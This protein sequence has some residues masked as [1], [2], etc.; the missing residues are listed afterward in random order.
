[1]FA[2]RERE[3]ER[4]RESCDQANGGSVKYWTVG[5]FTGFRRRPKTPPLVQSLCIASPSAPP[6]PSY[7]HFLHL[8]VVRSWY[9]VYALVMWCL[10]IVLSIVSLILA[11]FVVSREWVNLGI[12]GAWH[13]VL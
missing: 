6:H 2:L 12:V 9:L 7:T 5:S 1:M 10:K 11:V 4:E 8:Y 13:L 3:R